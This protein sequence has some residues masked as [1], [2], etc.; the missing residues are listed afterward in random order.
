VDKRG[1]KKQSGNRKSG[2]C[3]SSPSCQL[4]EKFRFMAPIPVG[5]RKER[6]EKSDINY[7]LREKKRRSS[8][9]IILST[10]GWF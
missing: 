9:V 8:V 4:I 5:K 10:S 6:R 3:S 7:F 1:Q 2:H